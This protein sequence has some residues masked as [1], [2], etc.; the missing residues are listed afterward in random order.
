M[1]RVKSRVHSALSYSYAL[2]I[3][4][5]RFS[6]GIANNT[7]LQNQ[8]DGVYVSLHGNRIIRLTPEGIYIRTT[9][10]TTPTTRQRLQQF[11][12]VNAYI[13]AGE[14]F[15]GLGVPVPSDDWLKVA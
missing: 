5:N 15:T 6:V 2:S 8:C 9:G 13:K 1:R 10:W 7:E 11:A 4:G 3:L 14:M 12:G